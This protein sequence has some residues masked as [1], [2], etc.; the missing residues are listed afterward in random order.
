MS[1]TVVKLGHVLISRGD[2]SKLPEGTK[3]FK[4]NVLQ[5]NGSAFIAKPSEQYNDGNAGTA[6]EPLYYLTRVP[7]NVTPN[8]PNDGWEVF[9]SD[10]AYVNSIMTWEENPEWVEVHLDA[11]QKVLYG[12][13]T[14]GEFFF[15]SGVP[16]QVKDYLNQ[17]IAELS[18]DEYESIV[19]FL[20]DYLGSD[21]TL[22]ML[23]DSKVDVEDGKSLMSS[24]EHTKLE[25]LPTNA[26]LITSLGNK[27]DVVEGKQLSTEDYTTEEK[28]KLG[29]LPTNAALTEALND[30]V[31]KETGKSLMTE[32]E[33]TKLGNLPN[34]ASLTDSLATKVDKEEG[35]GLST[36][37]YT[38]AD[39][40]LVAVHEIVENPEYIKAEVD[41]EGKLLAGRTTDGAAFENVGFSTPK[42]SIDGYTIENIQDPEG[43]TE[44]KTDSE[45]KILSYR[46]SKGVMHECGGINTPSINGTPIDELGGSNS[47]AIAPREYN[48]PKYGH[49]DIQ[50]ELS[51]TDGTNSYAPTKISKVGSQYYVTAT[52][53]DGQ[54][55][56]DS[57]EVTLVESDIDIT[58]W[59]ADKKTKHYC[60][61]DINF[62][63][64]LS[65]TFYIEV[66]YQGDSTLSYPKKNFRFTFYKDLLFT[67]KQKQK[68]GEFIETAKYNLKAYYLDNSIIREPACYRLVQAIMETRDYN[69]QYP[70]N[71]NYNIFTGATGITLNFP[72]RIDVSGEFYGINWF[73][74]AKDV[75][76]FMLDDEAMNGVL[77]Q[78]AGA[79]NENSTFWQQVDTE[80][81]DDIL[82]DADNSIGEDSLPSVQDFFDYINSRNG[83]AFNKETA[84]EH[85]N[86]NAWI[87]CYII[88]EL[89]CCTDSLAKNFML[90]AGSDKKVYWPMY[91]D[92]DYTFTNNNP[93]GSVLSQGLAW[94]K[95]LWIK[96][97]SLYWE[98]ICKRYKELR[99]IVIS[100]NYIVPFLQNLIRNFPYKDY[101]AEITKWGN[102]G[103]GTLNENIEWIKTR[104]NW[105]D[106]YFKI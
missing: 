53:V 82:G 106:D 89:L 17:K 50:K 103:I 92:M 87:D 19:A 60:K 71:P 79:A 97:K 51:F 30:K 70:W 43:R 42:M 69:E 25:A 28:T 59:P 72:T 102:H 81:W 46:D 91:Y 24:E 45:G 18:L 11:E 101:E 58:Q 78:G 55:V 93:E 84:S 37:D 12:V 67:K 62:G 41:S 3:F 94:D 100:A 23:I 86:I 6:A 9:A 65:G 29:A 56:P 52:L 98:E 85:L 38:N 95:S 1:Q 32:A 88:F 14:D 61:V 68:I 13:K 105:L 40:E 16:S 96:I 33:R 15:G 49:V 74:L 48:L 35:K 73:G 80:C 36:N 39:K 63:S 64:Y 4:D 75:D 10:A 47:S 7:Y 8:E 26:E 77:I 44:I 83:Y 76:N 99:H 22:K 20:D 31:D 2:F 34:N 5:Y 57:V 27:V 66:K 54:V 21:T 90:Y 104:I